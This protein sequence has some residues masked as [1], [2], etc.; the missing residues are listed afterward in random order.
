MKHLLFS[1]LKRPVLLPSMRNSLS[2]LQVRVSEDFQTEIAVFDELVHPEEP[3]SDFITR[4]TG[5]SND[6]VKKC[7]G[8]EEFWKNFSIFYNQQILFVDTI[9]DSTPIFSTSRDLGL[10]TKCSIR[11]RFRAFCC[12][13]NRVILLEILTEK[14]DIPHEDAHRHSPMFAPI[15]SFSTNL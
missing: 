1:I 10:K 12:Q 13:T 5:I 8:K 9:F 11:F 2:F 3:I 6:M 4:L 15:C 7:S 14:F